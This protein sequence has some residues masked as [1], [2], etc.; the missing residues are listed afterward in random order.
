ME[1]PENNPI[2]ATE[3][4]TRYEAYKKAV[5]ETDENMLFRNILYGTGGLFT[6]F[7]TISIPF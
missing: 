2:S 1:T 7:F 6:L 5:D 4:S 3:Y